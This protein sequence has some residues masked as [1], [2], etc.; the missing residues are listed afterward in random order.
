MRYPFLLAM[1]APSLP[2]ETP[3][4]AAPATKAMATRNFR[5][6]IPVHRSETAR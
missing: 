4:V 6:F 1:A 5:N 2:R 3:E